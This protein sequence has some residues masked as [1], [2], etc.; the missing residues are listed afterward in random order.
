MNPSFSLLTTEPISF[1]LLSQAHIDNP[2]K[3]HHAPHQNLPVSILNSPMPLTHP[4]LPFPL[5]LSPLPQHPLLLLL[6][7]YANPHLQKKRGWFDADDIPLA[8]LKKYKVPKNSSESIS[9]MELA[10]LS[11]TSL[12]GSAPPLRPM[13]SF[14]ASSLPIPL[15]IFG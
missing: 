8:I 2:L 7:I 6:Q 1:P 10:A 9:N 14:L 13:G 15:R 4:L 12:K 5:L 3:K 11:L